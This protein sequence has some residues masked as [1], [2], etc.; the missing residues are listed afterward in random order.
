[1]CFSMLCESSLNYLLSVLHSFLR[2]HFH[3]R[4]SFNLLKAFE[5]SLLAVKFFKHL[6]LSCC[7]VNTVLASNSFL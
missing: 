6:V 5:G 1:M 7:F 4:S 3:I 2:V